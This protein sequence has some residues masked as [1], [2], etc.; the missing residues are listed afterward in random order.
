MSYFNKIKAEG[1]FRDFDLTQSKNPDIIYPTDFFPYIFL[2]QKHSV[3]NIYKD[4]V[5]PVSST[6]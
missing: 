2:K 4:V 6:K 3:S 5:N 1:R